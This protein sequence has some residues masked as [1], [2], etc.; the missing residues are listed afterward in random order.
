MGH[1]ENLRTNSTIPK[2][3]FILIKLI[4][5]SHLTLGNESVGQKVYL[6]ELQKF[7]KNPL[8]CQKVS[9]YYNLGGHIL[10]IVAFQMDLSL[11]VSSE[12]DCGNHKV[13]LNF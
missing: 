3:F 4:V 2:L 1:N 9:T 11:K 13:Y 6:K 5:L 10:F 8:Q 12:C 7:L